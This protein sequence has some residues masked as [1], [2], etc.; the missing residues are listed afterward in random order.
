MAEHTTPA[1]TDADPTEDGPD[2]R[3]R[4]RDVGASR[5]ALYAT[6]TALVAFYLSPLEAGLMTA[7]KSSEA[8]AT[9]VPFVPPGPSGFSAEP[10][11]IAFDVMKGALINSALLAVPAAII[12]ALLGS[13]AAYGMTN[14]DWRGEIPIVL[15]FVAGI[16]IPYQAVLI[17][18]S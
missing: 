14:L 17:P 13:L 9:S 12:S 7:F 6:L 18:L 8:F 2:W 1:D 16:F 15:L 5:I 4:V 10:W 11:A 3:T